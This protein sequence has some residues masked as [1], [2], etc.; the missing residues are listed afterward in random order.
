MKQPVSAH[1]AMTRDRIM[2]AARPLFWRYGYMGVSVDAIC[3]AADVRKGSFYHAFTSKEELFVATITTTWQTNRHEIKQ[4]YATD[5]SLQDQFRHHLE[6]FG[7]SQKRLKAKCGFVPGPVNMA[8]DLGVPHVVLRSVRRSTNEHRKIVFRTIE[9]ILA[10]S[11]FGSDIALWMTGVVLRLIDGAY[12]EARL[13]NSL[14]PFDTLPGTAL[15]LMGLA[16]PPVSGVVEKWPLSLGKHPPL[17]RRAGPTK[18]AK[19][20][21]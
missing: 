15:A 17:K 7:I 2:E 21:T 10:L 16:P 4:I 3:A 9:Q 8:L 13:S 19:T 1:G 6:W 18:R 5:L 12:I 11:G 14:E 20:S